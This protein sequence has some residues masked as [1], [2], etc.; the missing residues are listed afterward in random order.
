MLRRKYITFSVPIKKEVANGKEEKEDHNG[1]KEE[2][3]NSKK[4]KTITYK[5]KFI[6]SYDLCKADYQTLLIT[7]LELTIRKANHA[8]KEK[9][10]NQ[11]VILV[12]L[13]IT[14]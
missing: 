1:K 11:N 2:D 14:N 9:K 7:Y 3:D 4:K 12:S 6:D 13:K 5:I 8:W 10:S